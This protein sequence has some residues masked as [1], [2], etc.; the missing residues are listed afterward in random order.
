VAEAWVGRQILNRLAPAGERAR[1]S[2]LAFHHVL[3][4]HD[5]LQPG[6]PS[7]A[8][9]EQRMRWVS[10]WFN[11]LP[12]AE[13]VDRLKDG[14]LPERPLAISFDDGYADNNDVA[15]PIL[16]KLGL[17]ATFFIATGYLDGGRMFND[18]VIEAIRQARDTVLDIDDFGLGV[19]ALAT[20]EE[21]RA[22]ID[23]ILPRVKYLPIGQ[24]EAVAGTIAERLSARLPDNLM[25]SSEQVAALHAAGMHIGGHT[26][27]HPILAG[28]P[29]E[30]ARDEIG[31]GRER[32][33]EITGAP[34]RLFAYP[35]GRPVRDYRREHAALVRELGFDAAVS[36]AWGSTRAGADLFQIP[37][38]TPWD[39]P[40]WRFG[41]RLAMN[42]LGNHVVRA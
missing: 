36:S 41:L 30:S 33:E 22:A 18:T 24:R 25:M 9:F 13:A 29:L 23:R 26:V 5:P 37:R 10:N 31:D 42:L 6:E 15:L 35:N 34:V 14:C 12:L 38:F 7:A 19:H 17:H 32:L 2:V 21:R 39:R 3:R 1:L 8:E 27:M 11:V 28:I 20:L 40:H 4:E 16:R